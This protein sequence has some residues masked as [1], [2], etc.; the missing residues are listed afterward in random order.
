VP[1]N[2]PAR[3]GR[4]RTELH[5][6]AKY[7]DA[8]YD[9]ILDLEAVVSRFA[10]ERERE[11]INVWTFYAKPLARHHRDRTTPYEPATGEPGHGRPE[12]RLDTSALVERAAKRLEEEG[13]R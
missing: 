5:H 11:S 2:D 6:L 12:R 3:G 4:L 8:G 1:F 9:P 7:L 10:N 13:F